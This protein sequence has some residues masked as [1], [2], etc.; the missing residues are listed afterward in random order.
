MKT[1]LSVVRT[2]CNYSQAI[3]A[4]AIGVSRQLV[5][6][7]ENG[8]KKLPDTRI[9]E[10]TDLF[11]VPSDLLKENDL[12]KVK[13]WCDRPMFST[14]IHGRQVF[15][16]EPAGC[17]PEI[18]LTSPHVPM[19]AVRSRALAQKRNLILQNFAAMAEVR[20]GQ[21]SKDLRDAEL[22][23]SILECIQSLLNCAGQSDPQVREQMMLFVLE[24]LSILEQVFAGIGLDKAE[25]T[26]WQRQ[27]LQMLRSHWAQV[28]RAYRAKA[29]KV[30]K[31]PP[32]QSSSDGKYLSERLNEWYHYAMAQGA[33]RRDLQFYLNQ[34]IMEEY[35]D[36]RQD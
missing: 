7:W 10:L 24:Q 1:A 13:Q 12:E 9:A 20:T 11:G 25:P 19:P 8:S 3:L 33:N 16:F 6:A 4:E 5:C 36:K 28:N 27:Q 14:E 34:I 23:I 18:F 26:R 2:R 35:D 31:H 21:Q 15:S 32:V 22:C 29:E 17:V 30:P